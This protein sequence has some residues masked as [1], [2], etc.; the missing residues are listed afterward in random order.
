MI[1]RRT[2]LKAAAALPFAPAPAIA[3]GS[4]WHP[5]R[6]VQIIV[7]FAPGGGTD[8]IAR[9]IQQA[10]ADLCPQPLVV[11]NQPGAGGAIAAERVAQMPPDGY[12]L[13]VAGGSESTSIPAHRP[14]PYDPQRSFTSVIR[15]TR[16]PHF[17]CVGGRDAQYDNIQRLLEAARAAPGTVPYASSGVGSLSH[18]IVLMLERRLG[19]EMLHVPYQGG[20]PQALAVIRGE[21]ALAIQA[22]DEL[23]PLAASGQLRPI[24]CTSEQR[25]LKWADVPTFRE[26]GIDLVA[27]NMKGLVAPAGL[28]PEV[29]RYWH[30]LFRRGM[31]Q[32]VWRAFEARTGE[33]QGYANGP[34]FQAAMDK[35]LIDIRSALGR[36]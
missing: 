33:G 3:Q 10:C 19:A 30:D 1:S 27:D 8:I 15:L 9:T 5:T 36:S 7:G 17:V 22:S 25:S 6:P 16:V 18:S 21:T 12:T 32:P 35:L 23:A 28:A 26:L 2:A 24:A 4:P 14:V 13:L 29:T 20:A 34:T 31:E 11:V